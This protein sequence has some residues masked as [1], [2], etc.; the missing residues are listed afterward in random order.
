MNGELHKISHLIQRH[1]VRF[2]AVWLTFISLHCP[3]RITSIVGILLTSIDVSCTTQM[4]YFIQFSLL[5]SLLSHLIAHVPLEN[6]LR[7]QID[8]SQYPIM[9]FSL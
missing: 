1:P 5:I 3:V 2:K 6:H 9:P 8:H 4:A 7:A